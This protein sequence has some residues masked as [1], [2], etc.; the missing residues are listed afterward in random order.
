M[1]AKW[2]EGAELADSPQLLQFY[3]ESSNS[4]LG[5]LKYAYIKLTF[6][7]WFDAL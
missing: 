4:I 2:M 6:R 5:Q 1:D 7:T 3:L